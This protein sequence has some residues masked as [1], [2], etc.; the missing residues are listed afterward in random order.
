MLFLCVFLL[1]LSLFVGFLWGFCFCFL[2]GFFVVGFFLYFTKRN[3]CNQH[4][5]SNFG[6]SYM[7]AK[8]N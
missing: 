2:L 6:V 3:I 4:I 7:F 8:E 5:L 1:L